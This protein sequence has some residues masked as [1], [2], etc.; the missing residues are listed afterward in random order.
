MQNFKVTSLGRDKVTFLTI[1]IIIGILFSLVNRFVMVQQ[2]STLY[3]YFVFIFV[4]AG[5][6]FL[7]FLHRSPDHRDILILILSTVAFIAQMIHF[8]YRMNDPDHFIWFALYPVM[9]FFLLNFPQSLFWTAGLFSVFFAEYIFV[10]GSDILF[11]NTTPWIVFSAFLTNVLLFSLHAYEI[12]KGDQIVSNIADMDFLT[13]LYNRKA[14]VTV[15]DNEI[16]RIKRNK[17]I[18]HLSIVMFQIDD[19]NIISDKYDHQETDKILIELSDIITNWLRKEDTVARWSNEEFIALFREA[20]I[21]ETR[22][23][24]EKLREKIE[25]HRFDYVNNITCSFGIAEYK[26][27]EQRNEIIKRADRA[28]SRAKQKGKNCI[29]V[30]EA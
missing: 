10:H 18:K 13:S 7:Y 29:V 26:T 23:V 15:F 14:F 27:N 30:D 3:N 1:V 19:F 6:V 16:K 9:Y 20:N 11:K 25:K 2:A 8:Y 17:N 12:K 28:L 24:V 5:P 21:A 22:H 4:L